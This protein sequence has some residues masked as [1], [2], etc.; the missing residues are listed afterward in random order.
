MVYNHRRV[1]EEK[2]KEKEK[3]STSIQNFKDIVTTSKQK[4]KTQKEITTKE[5][6]KKCM[7]AIVRVNKNNKKS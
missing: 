5:F 4:H 6:E 3:Q 7:Q 2:E 1:E